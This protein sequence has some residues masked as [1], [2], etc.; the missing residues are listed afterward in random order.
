MAL[1]K[2]A[3]YT[4]LWQ[5]CDALRG[6]MD[7]SQYKDY[8]LALLFVKYISDK[9]TG[10][11]AEITVPKGASF[12]DMTALKGKPDIGDRINKNILAPIAEAND[13]PPFANF[14]DE[15][16]LGSGQDRV[17]R[18]TALIG[19][20]ENLDFT[21]NRADGDDILGDAY[22][23]LMRH[24]ATESGKSKGQFYTPPEV[25]RVI[26]GITGIAGA[27]TTAGTTVYDP[28][29]GSG[30]L[31]LKMGDAADANISLYGQEK[32]I[33][34]QG[35]ARMNMVLHGFATAAI[36]GGNTLTSPRFQRGEALQ[37]FDYV[38]ANPPFSDKAW[39]LGLV[40][41]KDSWERFHLGVPPEKNGD[42]AYLLHILASMSPAGKGVCVLPHGV[43]FRGNAEAGIRRELIRR[44]V[45]KGIIGLPPNLFYGTGI[46]A[47]LIVLDKENAAARKGIFMIDASRDYAKDGPKNRLRARDIHRII[48]VFTR[49]R[50]IPGYSRLVSHQ[51]IIEKNNSNLNLPRYIDSRETEDS[52]NIEAHLRGGIPAKDVEK[53]AACWQI[54]PGLKNALFTPLPGRPGCLRLAIE[55]GDIRRTVQQH[56]EMLAFKQGVRSRYAAWQQK[57]RPRLA[58]FRQGEPGNPLGETTAEDLLAHFAGQPLIDNYAVYQAFMDLWENT[59]QDDC[60]SISQNGWKPEIENIV[61]ITRNGKNKGQEKNKGWSCDLT[62]KPLVVAR[63]FPR[64]QAAIDRLQEKLASLQEEQ[65]ALEE[66]DAEAQT[67][68]LNQKSENSGE[69]E[70]SKKKAVAEIK[71]LIKQHQLENLLYAEEFARLEKWRQLSNTAGKLKKDLRE[72]EKALDAA[73]QNRIRQLTEEE[74]K[75][76]VINDK[77]LAQLAQSLAVLIENTEQQLISRIQELAARYA[78]PLPELEAA[79]TEQENKVRAHLKRMG[80]TW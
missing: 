5:S 61:E 40:P 59:M 10:D 26:T 32:D 9:Y 17:D 54:C 55:A 51:E 37:T 11:Y 44:G 1:K 38:V 49:Q 65:R 53:L 4:R 16:K 25:S 15:A 41:E 20:F 75:N 43:L 22:E 6:G 73:A 45:I 71:K 67:P 27:K 23:Y 58:A 29:C 68:V 8:V 64:E 28:T 63:Y 70:K 34:T 24:F 50:E 47:C 57:Q 48:D 36:E 3:I 39:S 19:I 78:R 72:K 35:L 12:A 31:L 14:N 56:P 79:V 13:L 66:E 2:S 62:P 18:L 52:Q 42:Y 60:Y 21:R 30:S 7:A 76:L 77:W 69:K 46:P 74:T 80:F 33:A